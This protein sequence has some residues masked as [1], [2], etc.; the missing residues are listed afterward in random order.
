MTG[1]LF[2]HIARRL[3]CGCFAVAS[4]VAAAVATAVAAAIAAAVADTAVVADAVAAEA[5]TQRTYP[6]SLGVIAASPKIQVIMIIYKQKKMLAQRVS[7]FTL[8]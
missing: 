6:P 7:F 5:E 3:D 8:I 2:A 1:N 4:A